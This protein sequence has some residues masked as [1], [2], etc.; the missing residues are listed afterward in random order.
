MFGKFEAQEEVKMTEEEVAAFELE[1]KNKIDALY[2]EA[3]PIN[4]K[5]K[6][7]VTQISIDVSN[8]VHKEGEDKDAFYLEREKIIHDPELIALESELQVIDKEIAR[9]SNLLELHHEDRR[10]KGSDAK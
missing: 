4:Q 10:K 9:L 2:K 7:K 8:V 3:E 5:I 1:T 6:E